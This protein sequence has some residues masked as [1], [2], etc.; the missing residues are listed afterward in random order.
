VQPPLQRFDVV[1][2]LHVV[3]AVSQ[4]SVTQPPAGVI[5]A[6]PG[7]RPHHTVGDEP[8]LLLEGPH[9]SLDFVVKERVEGGLVGRQDHQAEAAEMVTKLRHGGA[10]V[11]G[12]VRRLW[13]DTSGLG[14]GYPEGTWLCVR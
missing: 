3:N 4:D 2:G 11:A 14:L 10:V 5:E 7:R 8:S 1:S 6:A 13:H 12:A 9:R